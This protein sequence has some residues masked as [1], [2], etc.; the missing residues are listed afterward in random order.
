MISWPAD[1]PQY[2]RRT[3]FRQTAPGGVLRTKTDTGPGKARRRFSSAPAPLSCSI[4]VDLAGLARFRRFFEE[5]LANGAK[6]FLMRDQEFD[7]ATLSDLET[8]TGEPIDVVAQ[9]IVM[10]AEEPAHT[11]FGMMFAISM[12]LSLMP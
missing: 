11:S 10:F 7:G 1:L 3:D 9:R 8:E 4:T 2:V 5:E 6:P 12:S